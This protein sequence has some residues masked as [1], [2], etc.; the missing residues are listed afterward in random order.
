[1]IL[2]PYSN[3]IK[4]TQVFSITDLQAQ[5]ALVLY[6]LDTLHEVEDRK[7]IIET[8]P[9]E[10]QDAWRGYETQLAWYGMLLADEVIKRATHGM[11]AGRYLY[12]RMEWHLA[13]ATSG[14]FTME[15]PPWFGKP[16]IHLSHQSV[17]IA[18]DP[19]H[20]KAKFP[21]IPTGLPL[22]WA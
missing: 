13:T 15:R 21:N 22:V 1:M 17:L 3:Y 12:K 9:C 10:C 5:A 20:Y 18:M 11:S 7:T 4:N 2:L 19:K 14:R 6:L 16:E 8:F